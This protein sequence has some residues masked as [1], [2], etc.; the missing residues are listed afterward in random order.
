MGARIALT[1]ISVETRER[2]CGG[3]TPKD[4]NRSIAERALDWE[5]AAV[6]S[7]IN[8]VHSDVTWSIDAREIH[9]VGVWGNAACTSSARSAYNI[10]V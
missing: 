8:R 2:E 6:L 9:V 3:D 4:W 10:S 5:T 1:W 7:T